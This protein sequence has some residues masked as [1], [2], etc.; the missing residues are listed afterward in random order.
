MNGEHEMVFKALLA[1]G[2]AMIAAQA[3]LA[4][5]VPLIPRAKLFG[6]PT[7]IGGKL[8]PDGKWISFIAPRDGVLN[9]WVAPIATPDQARPLTAEKTRPIRQAFWSPD[10]KSILFVNDKGGDE[11]PALRRQCRDRRAKGADPVR[12]D[13]GPD[14]RHQRDDPRPYPGRR[15]QSRSALA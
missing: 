11:F 2:A 6:N 4:A 7:K 9:V 3:T 13:A 8:S 12:E 10:S 1:A 15:Q 5:D 14:H